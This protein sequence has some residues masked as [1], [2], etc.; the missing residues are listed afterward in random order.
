MNKRIK[1]KRIQLNNKKLVKRY[2]FLLA[3]NIW[4]NKPSKNHDYSYTLADDILPG[5]RKAFGKEFFEELRNELIK[6]KCL[7]TF[8]IFE[9]KEKYGYLTIY[10]MI[11]SKDDSNPKY[12][13]ID[14]IINKYEE[15]SSTVCCV[16]G[17]RNQEIKNYSGWYSCI[18]DE[19]RKYY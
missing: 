3:K 17:K 16:C 14:N 18:C 13:N 15:L 1:K 9:I 12:D 10:Y 2:P 6:C 19:C 7:N 11:N 8:N 4:T 5:W